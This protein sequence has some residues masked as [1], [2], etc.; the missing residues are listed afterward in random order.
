M[1]GNHPKT[2]RGCDQSGWNF[3]LF[4]KYWIGND[5]NIVGIHITP[6]QKSGISQ[7]LHWHDHFGRLNTLQ[8]KSGISLRLHLRDHLVDST[9]SKRRVGSTEYFIGTTTSS[10]TGWI[11]CETT[12]FE[13][14]SPSKRRVGLVKDCIRMSTSSTKGW[15]HRETTWSEGASPPKNMSGVGQIN[16][17]ISIEENMS[18]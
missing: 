17:A 8:E 5:K 13:G 12:W 1:K 3:P 16:I 2:W 10:T 9:L 11:G 18:H 15:I 6:Y 7:I 4:W 14:K